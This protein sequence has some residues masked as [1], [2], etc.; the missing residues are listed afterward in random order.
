MREAIAWSRAG[1][2]TRPSSPPGI[3]AALLLLLALSGCPRAAQAPAARLPSSPDARLAA[4]R[5]RE[6]QVQ[7]L[8]ARFSSVTR[9]GEEE[10]HT[11]GVLLVAKPDRFRMRLMLPFG[12]TVF[13]YLNV[14]EQTWMTLPLAD[15]QQRER[16]GAFAPFS[17]QDLAEAFLR[18]PYAF[19]GECTPAPAAGDTVWVSCHVA[20]AL[21]RTYL[22]GADGIAE[23]TSYDGDAPRMH[24]AYTDYRAAGGTTLPF[25]ITLDYPQRQQSVDITI[26]RYEV[27]PS[28]SDDL[29]APAPADR[30]N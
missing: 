9:V 12:F 30:A 19:P 1:R 21:R 2:R 15:A 13:D 17:R 18:G 25:R 10:R 24:I 11:D 14:G 4:V 29:F 23:E 28:L 5:A 26:D 8:R 7:T 3:R 16:A 22:I 20:G 27:N 6:D